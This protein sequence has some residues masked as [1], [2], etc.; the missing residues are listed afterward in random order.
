MQYCIYPH[1]VHHLKKT[2]VIS[3]IL[4]TLSN[5]HI[6]YGQVCA[7]FI[8]I[9]DGKIQEIPLVKVS[10]AL[11]EQN[12]ERFERSDA[13]GEIELEIPADQ[14]LSEIYFETLNGLIVR[15]K[16]VPINPNKKLNLGQ[17]IMPEFKYI[18]IAEY[19]RLTRKQ[20]TEC[21]PDAH[22]TDIYGYLYSNELEYD[23]LILK[24]A[25]TDKKIKDFTF[26]PKSKIITLDWDTFNDCG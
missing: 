26:D 9:Y 16:D 12:E 20:K 10:F 15:I 6:G 21:I 14:S 13:N 8:E 24:C 4:L 22:Y 3:F 5:F 18:S 7:Q 17:I 25:K 1:V 23:Y 2:F 11:N 19:D